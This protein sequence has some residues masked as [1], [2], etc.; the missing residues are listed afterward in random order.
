MDVTTEACDNSA[1]GNK[2]YNYFNF[3][4]ELLEWFLVYYAKIIG[5]RTVKLLKIKM[6]TIMNMQ[7]IDCVVY[8]F[9]CFLLVIQQ[10]VIL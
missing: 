4:P 10:F 6:F 2:D 9:K 1:L 7:L 8:F 3:I 5:L